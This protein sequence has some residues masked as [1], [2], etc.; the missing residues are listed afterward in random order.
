MFPVE[1]IYKPNDK[2][3]NVQK[4]KHILNT[5]VLKPENRQKYRGHILVFCT[6]VDEIN[7]LC[8]QYSNK[9]QI[10]PLPLHGKLTSDEQKLIFEPE[11]HMTKL[12]FAS[13]IA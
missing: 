3:T 8:T 11:Q 4:I 1:I 10:R 13:R 7:T 5:E 9:A 6:T 12:I 2:S